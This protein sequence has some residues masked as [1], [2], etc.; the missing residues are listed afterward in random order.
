MTSDLELEN[1]SPSLEL[2]TTI[3]VPLSKL[4]K[5][6]NVSQYV[7]L[8][9]QTVELSPKSFGMQLKVEAKTVL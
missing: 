6:S 9:T 3:N 4:S 2:V 5:R 7:E 1:R 8:H